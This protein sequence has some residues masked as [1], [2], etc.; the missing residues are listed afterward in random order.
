M[1]SISC[2][3]I[4]DFL[5]VYL[6]VLPLLHNYCYNLFFNKLDWK[7]KI[8][9]VKYF[10]QFCKDESLKNELITLAHSYGL[11][12][13]QCISYTCVKRISFLSCSR[14]GILW[15]TWY[16]YIYTCLG[17]YMVISVCG[18]YTALYG[19]C[20]AFEFLEIKTACYF[21]KTR[22]ILFPFYR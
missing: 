1:W 2:S 12:I 21:D 16:L 22:V 14:T 19:Y 17:I 20:S 8:I 6:I 18:Y 9:L 11:I 7:Y 5:W 10:V 4:P 15:P 3:F 13:Q